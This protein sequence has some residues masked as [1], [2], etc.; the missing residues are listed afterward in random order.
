MCSI[1][2]PKVPVSVLILNVKT[3]HF[4][5]QFKKTRIKWEA[6]SIVSTFGKNYSEIIVIILIVLKDIWISKESDHNKNKGWGQLLS[7]SFVK[8]ITFQFAPGLHCYVIMNSQNTTISGTLKCII[9]TKKG[10]SYWTSFFLF[11]ILFFL[12]LLFFFFSLVCMT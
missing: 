12:N 11:A 7:R 10:F 9:Y 5:Y 6:P 4:F 3:E 2:G 1:M 8:L